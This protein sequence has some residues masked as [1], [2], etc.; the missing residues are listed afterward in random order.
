MPS[1]DDDLGLEGSKL[2]GIDLFF[3]PCLSPG[4]V[5]PQV[6]QSVPKEIEIH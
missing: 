6:F 5:S 4:L 1:E 2:G 3:I